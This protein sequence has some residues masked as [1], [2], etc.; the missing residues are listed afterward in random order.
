MGASQERSSFLVTLTEV[1]ISDRSWAPLIN[2]V[3]AQRRS[4]N[5]AH[6]R[7]VAGVNAA[8]AMTVIP[9]RLGKR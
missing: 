1:I 6:K 3:R 4:R 8:A 7:A 5:R 9:G 2:A